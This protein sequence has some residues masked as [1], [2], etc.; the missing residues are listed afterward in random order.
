[1]MNR[2]RDQALFDA[3]R[4]VRT[5]AVDQMRIIRPRGSNQTY[6]A[7]P[8]SE[9]VPANHISVLIIGRRMT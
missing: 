5:T 8:F 9:L 1:M 3:I 6:R 7:Q 4:K 2:D